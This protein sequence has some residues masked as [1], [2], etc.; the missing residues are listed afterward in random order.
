[1]VLRVESDGPFKKLINMARLVFGPGRPARYQ[2]GS[3]DLLDWSTETRI[4]RTLLY[5]LERHC[6]FEDTQKL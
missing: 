2:T 4:S 6:V 5:V 1:M 3:F